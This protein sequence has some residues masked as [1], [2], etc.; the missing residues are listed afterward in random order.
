MQCKGRV[1]KTGQ[2]PEDIHFTRLR[3]CCNS[4]VKIK[5]TKHT[6]TGYQN[7]IT[8]IPPVYTYICT[9]QCIQCVLYMCSVRA[10]AVCPLATLPILRSLLHN[11]VLL[12]YTCSTSPQNIKDLGEQSLLLASPPSS[13]LLSRSPSTYSAVPSGLDLVTVGCEVRSVR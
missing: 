3:C 6:N 5:N 12:L 7:T 4:A 8:P 13:R 10:R 9:I 1:K 2:C 11:I